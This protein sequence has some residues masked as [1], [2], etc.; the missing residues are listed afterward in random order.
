[1]VL[2]I[3]QTDPT[4]A[5]APRLEHLRASRSGDRPGR[6]HRRCT[7][8]RE[9]SLPFHHPRL[10]HQ[11]SSLSFTALS[12]DSPSPDPRSYAGST[13]TIRTRGICTP[14]FVTRPSTKNPLHLCAPFSIRSIHDPALRIIKPHG[15][16]PLVYRSGLAPLLARMQ[17][18]ICLVAGHSRHTTELRKIAI[19]FGLNVPHFS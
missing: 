16:Y 17:I 14:L 12:L 15:S 7:G 19:G 11:P 5:L 6:S 2:R 1:M 13:I 18:G 9:A 8:D 10:N 4:T 3:G